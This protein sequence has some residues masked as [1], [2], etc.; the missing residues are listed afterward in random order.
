MALSPIL[1]LICSNVFMTTAWHGHL[2]FLP[3]S[4]IWVAILIS[5]GIALC[6]WGSKGRYGVKAVIAL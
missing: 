5:W 2:R 4:R 1:L 3:H 6:S